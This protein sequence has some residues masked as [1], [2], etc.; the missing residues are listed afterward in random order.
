MRA[1]LV[2]TPPAAV[3]LVPKQAVRAVWGAARPAALHGPTRQQGRE[4]QGRVPWP[5]REHQGQELAVPRRAEVACGTEPALAAPSRFGRGSPFWAPA[6]GWGARTM[7]P[8][9]SWPSPA[10]L[11]ARSAWA[12]AAANLRSQIPALRPREKRLATVR[13]GP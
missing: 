8:S 10:I 3:A 12:G 11:P 7:G 9:P 5:W 6:A 4:A 1:S 2:P 13:P